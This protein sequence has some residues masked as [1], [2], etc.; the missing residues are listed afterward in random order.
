VQC[1]LAVWM[2]CVSRSPV[3]RS[4]DWIDEIERQWLESF[5]F[6]AGASEKEGARHE[7]DIHGLPIWGGGE[8]TVE[9]MRGKLQPRR[10]YAR[11]EMRRVATVHDHFRRSVQRFAA[12]RC[13]LRMGKPAP[14]I[15]G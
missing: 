2:I 12:G 7:E 14:P 9:H 6:S 11:L 13:A 1:V 4:G 15:N 10:R 3:E 8:L 5:L